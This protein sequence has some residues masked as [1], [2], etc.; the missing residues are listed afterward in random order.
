[1]QKARQGRRWN[2]VAK[3]TTRG[4]LATAGGLVLLGVVLALALTDGNGPTAP[5]AAALGRPAIVA[6]PPPAVP[7]EP[8]AAGGDCGAAMDAVRSLQHTYPS[9]SML[10]EPADQELNADLARLDRACAGAPQLALL[11]RTRELNPWLTYLPPDP[12]ATGAAPAG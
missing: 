1:V 3:L 5:A 10:P 2:G 9:G 8:V 6:K 4:L 7:P 12:R 11:F